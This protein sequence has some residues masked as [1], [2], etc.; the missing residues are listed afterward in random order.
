V[1]TFKIDTDKIMDQC[2]RRGVRAYASDAYALVGAYARVHAYASL[3]N[4]P[5]ML[6]MFCRFVFVLHM[7]GVVDSNRKL[8]M[9][10]VLRNR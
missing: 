5:Q 8:S 2:Q 10:L 6:T 7:V 9:K 1:K 3:K 4:W